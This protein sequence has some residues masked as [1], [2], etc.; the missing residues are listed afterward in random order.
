MNRFSAVIAGAFAWL[1]ASSQTPANYSSLYTGLP[2][3]VAQVTPVTFPDRSASIISHGATG[4][5]VTLN[6]AAIQGCIDSLATLGGGTVE[7]PSGV[8]LT[9]PLEL[10]SNICLHL[11]PTAILY[12]SPDKSLYDDGPRSR[13]KPCITAR[14]CT[15]IGITGRGLIDGNGVQWRPVKRGKVSPTEWSRFKDMGGVERNEGNMWYPWELRSGYPDLA[16]TPEKQEGRR[17][18]LFRVFDCSGIL[19]KDVTFQNSP[20]FHVHPFNSENIIIDGITVRCPWNA[21]NGDA[22]DLSDCHRCLITGATVDAGDDGICLK[23]GSAKKG[24]EI[25]GVHDVLIQDCVVYA[26]HGGFVIG[27]EDICGIKRV[28]CRDCRFSGTETGLR[29]KSAISRGGVTRDIYIT[30]V[31]MSD[32]IHSAVTFECTYNLANA[33]IKPGEVDQSKPYN[34]PEFTDIHISD[35]VCRGCKTGVSASGINGFNCV[36]DIEISNS[37]FVY[38]REATAIDPATASLNLTDVNFVA[39]R[40][41]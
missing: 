15:N 32:I 35:I 5:A 7:I 28:V 31:M 16:P 18:D 40:K 29:F 10:R 12:F 8:W 41:Q 19:L 24:T 4:D 33:N 17:N 38:T 9:G 2:V 39:D 34:V 11:A 27:S 21:Q 26:A 37:T 20:K 30:R 13:F 6:T 14:N 36:H 23:S 22:I 3:E 25:N 1:A